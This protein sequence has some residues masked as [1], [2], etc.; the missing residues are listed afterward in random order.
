MDLALKSGWSCCPPQAQHVEHDAG[1]S[2]ATVESGAIKAALRVDGQGRH[3]P[4]AGTLTALREGMQHGF[5]TRLINHVDNPVAAL[6]ALRGGAIQVARAVDDHTS[7]R[8][9]PVWTET[10]LSGRT[11]FIEDGYVSMRIDF[12]NISR[13]D[14]PVP[15]AEPADFGRGVEIALP[16]A[17]YA[18]VKSLGAKE[19]DQVAAGGE[20]ECRNSVGQ[21]EITA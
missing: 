3:R 19:P 1:P 11:E 8:P 13:S 20:F 15:A 14:R 10:T 5:N 7:F 17:G 18:W 21:I 2:A 6:A 4:I 9:R 12:E 16:V